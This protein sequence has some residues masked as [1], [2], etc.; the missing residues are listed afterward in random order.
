MAEMRD[1]CLPGRSR[2]EERKWLNLAFFN[3]FCLEILKG[4]GG[5]SGE[6]QRVAQWIWL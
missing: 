1:S 2:K 3:L 5:W 4:F 6:R